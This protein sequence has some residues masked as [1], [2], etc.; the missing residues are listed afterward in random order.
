MF[1]PG[2]MRQRLLHPPGGHRH[3]PFS[4]FSE[5]HDEI[6]GVMLENG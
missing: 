3:T 6:V 4:L 5:K 1:A 2:A